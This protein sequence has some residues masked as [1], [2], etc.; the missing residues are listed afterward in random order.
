[1]ITP[2]TGIKQGDTKIFT[3]EDFVI[4]AEI[5]HMNLRPLVEFC[6]DT[7]LAPKLHGFSMRY[8]QQ[9]LEEEMRTSAV[10]KKSNFQA[11]LSNI[12][13]KKVDNIVE[14]KKVETELKPTIQVFN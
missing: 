6:R 8:S 7:R 13:K 10:S 14:E 4:K 2:K 3:V 1:M 9:A 12:S 5:D 11:F